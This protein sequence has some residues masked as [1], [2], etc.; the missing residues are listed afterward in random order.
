L[1]A[2][3]LIFPVLNTLSAATYTA[4]VNYTLHCQGCHLA[5]GSGTPDKVPALKNE[6]GRFLQVEGGRE[7]LIQV[8]GTSQSPMSDAEIADVLNWMLKNF[9]AEQLPA[10]FVPYTSEEVSRV[11]PEPLANVSAVRARLVAGRP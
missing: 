5:D 3:A 10:D 7:F 1:A 11:R 8:P 6:V 9:S 4:Q 2:G